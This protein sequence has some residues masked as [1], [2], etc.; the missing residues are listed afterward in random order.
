MA[1]RVNKVD[2]N[3]TSYGIANTILQNAPY[4]MGLNLPEITD[5]HTLRKVGE[6]VMG[7]PTVKNY[8][9]TELINRIALVKITSVLFNNPYKNLKKG[10]LE[11]GETIE[12]IYVALAKAVHFDPAKAPQRE[13]KRTIP[14]V[15]TVFYNINWR[16]VYPITVQDEDL[17]RAFLSEDGL[18]D[19][20]NRIIDSI[21]TGA[22][23]DEFLLFKYL[24]IKEIAHGRT[25]RRVIDTS[26]MNN[27]AVAFKSISN[28]FTFITNEFNY[29]RVQ[30]NT[31]IERQ[32]IFMDSEFNARFDVEVLARA[33]NMNK[34]DFVGRLYLI[35]HFNTFDNERFKEIQ[36]NTDSLEE[37]T[38]GE[39]AL[40]NE[41]KAVLTDVEYFQIYDNLLTLRRTQ[42]GSG[43][44]DNYWLHTWKTVC[45]SP[46]ANFVAF[47]D[48]ENW[49]T[50]PSELTLE[51]SSIS[52]NDYSEVI[53]FRSRVDASFTNTKYD[54]RII[55][56]QTEDMTERFIAS[57]PFGSIM[58]P[59]ND[60]ADITLIVNIG[61]NT[62]TG[63]LTNDVAVG[64][65]V[66]LAVTNN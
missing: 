59:V 8:F 9:L 43:L 38:E 27:V 1:K 20:I 62:Y 34:A 56:E 45:P 11:F 25:A 60:T 2:Y 53:N 22:E 5:V 12:D 65:T 47:V 19:L 15:K 50:S 51:V 10:Y 42:V 32:I 49:D 63:T 44:Y 18:R 41:V 3:A 61:T 13:F 30:N 16:V 37:V 23:Y 52:R 58:K 6:F 31:P 28:Q 57:V 4:D 21:Y 26:D 64:D 55:F 35:D 24:L 29:A 54:N 33:F 14:D 36:E 66:A 39:L 40:M 7:N 17:K 46:F 48:G